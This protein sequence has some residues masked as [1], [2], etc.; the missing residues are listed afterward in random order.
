MQAIQATDAAGVEYLFVC[1]ENNDFS[2]GWRQ[3]VASGAAGYVATPWVYDVNGLTVG[4]SYTF[5]VKTRDRSMS[6]NE[7]DPSSSVTVPI[8]AVD[9]TPPTVKGVTPPTTKAQITS[10]G[11]PYNYGG[12]WYQIVTATE[13]ED[14]NGVEYKF[15]SDD[16]APISGNNALWRYDVNATA[17]TPRPTGTVNCS[18]LLDPT[19]A[20]SSARTIW[21]NVGSQFARYKY[22]VQYRDQSPAANTG[23][24]SNAAQAP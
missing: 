19:G 12:V 11:A 5:Y 1:V 9:Q 13:A 21:V 8:V 22:R 16:G 15:T 10:V 3:N 20:K 17:P 23:T 18:L 24:I 14:P 4:Q 7:T 2:S 6:Q